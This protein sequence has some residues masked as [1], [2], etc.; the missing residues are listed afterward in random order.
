[1]PRA[2]SHSKSTTRISVELEKRGLLHFEWVQILPQCGNVALGK[3]LLS[4]SL[5]ENVA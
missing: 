5:G 4:F 1:M 2:A 3:G